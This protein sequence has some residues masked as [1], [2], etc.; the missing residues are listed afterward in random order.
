M[1]LDKKGRPRPDG[2]KMTIEPRQ[3]AVVLRIFWSFADGRSESAIVK[4]LNAEGIPGR[5]KAQR[6][7]SPA[8]VHRM[9]RNEKYAGRWSGIGPRRDAIHAPAVPAISEARDKLGGDE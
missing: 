7:W 6:G 2:Y 5:R 9:L 1:R 4:E 3:T 8:T